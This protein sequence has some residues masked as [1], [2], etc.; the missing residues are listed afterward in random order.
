MNVFPVLEMILRNLVQVW[1][2]PSN[3]INR[4]IHGRPSCFA[5]L[6]LDLVSFGYSIYPTFCIE[7]IYVRAQ[8]QA[9][10]M[11]QTWQFQHFLVISKHCFL[12]HFKWRIMYFPIQVLD[13]Q[14]HHG[15]V[16]L[17]NRNY[18]YIVSSLQPFNFLLYNGGQP[19]SCHCRLILSGSQ[20]VEVVSGFENERIKVFTTTSSYTV[21][22]HGSVN[23]L[24]V[25]LPKLMPFDQ[26]GILMHL[27]NQLSGTSLEPRDFSKVRGV[28]VTEGS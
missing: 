27:S 22:D 24:P 11:C 7:V 4:V 25:V 15:C 13:H 17:C 6:R 2:E 9:Q 23:F 12:Y 16:I 26:F 19:L 1:Y 28:D 21:Q 3:F 5:I 8:T 20:K 14:S 10:G 18:F